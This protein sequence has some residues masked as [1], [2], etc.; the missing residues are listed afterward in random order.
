MFA[1]Y[2]NTRVST[3]QARLGQLEGAHEECRREVQQVKADR[4]R[5]REECQDEIR[6]LRKDN[7]WLMEMAQRHYGVRR[8]P[9]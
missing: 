1:V 4:D 8:P 3:F 9:R 7:E 6:R 2:R 5:D